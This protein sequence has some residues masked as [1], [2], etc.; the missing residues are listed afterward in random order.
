MRFFYQ[1]SPFHYQSSPFHYQKLC[2]KKVPETV[3]VGALW[4]ELR[5]RNFLF[6]KKKFL[7]IDT[8]YKL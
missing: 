8:T 5:K 3:L 2:I 1:S 7:R 6:E 4:I